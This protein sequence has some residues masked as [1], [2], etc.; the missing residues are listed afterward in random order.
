MLRKLLK[1]DFGAVIKLWCIGALAVLALSVGGG[2]CI[3]VLSSDRPF[4]GIINLV[5]G[6]GVFLSVLSIVAFTIL[7]I[8]LLAMRYYKNLFTDEG[9]LTFTLPVRL[10]TV[11]NSKLIMVFTMLVLTGIVTYLANMIIQGIGIENYFEILKG[12]FKGFGEFLKEARKEGALGWVI[13]Y[14]TEAVCIMFFTSLFSVLF[15]GCCI[16]FGSVVAKKA[17]VLASIGIYLGANWLFSVVVMIFLVF[18]IMAFGSWVD[19]ANLTDTQIAQL[20]GLLMFGVVALQAMLC[21]LLYT[22]QYRLLDRKLNL[23]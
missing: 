11:I 20:V 7:T 19:G 8:V 15:L 17:K 12:T 1:Y 14:A 21:S 23:P 2:L 10:H 5:A 18:G 3:R 16:T 4:H 13:L 6:L 9:Y 22:L